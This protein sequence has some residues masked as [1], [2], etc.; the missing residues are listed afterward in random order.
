[1]WRRRGRVLVVPVSAHGPR[2]GG[3]GG[4]P[5]V[6]ALVQHQVLAEAALGAG[7]TSVRSVEADG[8]EL[9]AVE[10][11]EADVEVPVPVPDRAP[12]PGTPVPESLGDPLQD[13]VGDP[14]VAQRPPG[15]GALV[16]ELDG[17]GAIAEVGT[18]VLVVA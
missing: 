13:V 14:D 6:R 9:G 16:R 2:P 5:G 8:R 1:A 12:A 18:I 3:R 17:H 7:P 15:G 11:V 10:V 4:K